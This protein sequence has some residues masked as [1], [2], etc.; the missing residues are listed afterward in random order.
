M[1]YEGYDFIHF[2][3]SSIPTM[4]I[5]AI[6]RISYALKKIYEGNTIKDS[7]P[8]SLDRT[9]NLKLCTMLFISHSIA[10]SVNVGKIYF[11]KNPLAINYPEWLT[12]AKY[13][14][15]QLKW[16]IMQKPQ[17]KEA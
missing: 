6:V 4:L 12:F 1:Y 14:Y 13:S 5:E 8:F 2:C 9:K 3:S 15:K 11:K 7:I 17:L 16:M 10:C